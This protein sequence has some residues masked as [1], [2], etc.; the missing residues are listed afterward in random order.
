MHS[1]YLYA[2][3]LQP[4]DIVLTDPG[5]LCPGQPQ[6]LSCRVDKMDPAAVS[7]KWFYN[8]ATQSLAIIDHKT[9]SKNL[10]KCGLLGQTKFNSSLYLCGILCA[11]R[12]D[13]GQSS[14]C[15]GIA[16][17]SAHY[18]IVYIRVQEIG[19]P[20]LWLKTAS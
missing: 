8:D 1:L 17:A 3:I 9:D 14:V 12:H 6:E 7:V 15:I 16:A 4:S 2:V 13:G 5:P 11:Y 19:E 10:L 20:L 18:G